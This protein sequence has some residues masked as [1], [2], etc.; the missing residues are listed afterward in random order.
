[1]MVSASFN[2]FYPTRRAIA[3]VL[4][5][6]L[7]CTIIIIPRLSRLGGT[8]AFLVLTL[9]EL[10]FSVQEDMAQQLE[11]TVLNIMG[12]VIGVG[13]STLA[14]YISSISSDNSLHPRL[15]SAVFLVVISFFGE[16]P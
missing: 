9:K 5:T 1:M 13:F 2:H 6:F 7:C 4:S 15:I 14:K 3:R 16:C 12:A 8:S 10:V 11:A